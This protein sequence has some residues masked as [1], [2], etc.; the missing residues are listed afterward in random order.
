MLAL[1]ELRAFSTCPERLDAVDRVCCCVLKAVC[2]CWLQELRIGWL[3]LVEVLVL[4]EEK[5]E[6]ELGDKE[7]LVVE[8]GVEEDTA[9]FV[10]T[11]VEDCPVITVDGDEKEEERIP[12]DDGNRVHR[13][14]CEWLT[15]AGTV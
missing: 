13:T 8:T 7:T 4:T 10:A 15:V 1:K 2:I 9:V 3:W 11:D 12:G 6:A 5:L 14:C